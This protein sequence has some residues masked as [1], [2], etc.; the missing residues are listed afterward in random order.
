MPAPVFIGDE[1]SAAGWR[2]AGMRIV[3]PEPGQEAEALLAVLSGA[4]E[5]VLLSS[6]CASALPPSLLERF[7]TSL[8]PLTLLVPDVQGRSTLPDL[9]AQVR[10]RMGMTL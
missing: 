5:L 3:V 1:V 6:V 7:L 4:T 10:A 8:T 2:L 9:S